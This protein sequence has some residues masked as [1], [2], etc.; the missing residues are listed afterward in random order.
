MK[1][2]SQIKEF[3]LKEETSIDSVKKQLDAL[4]IKYE[5]SGNEFRPFKVIYKPVNKSDKFYN[6]FEDIIDLFNLR[7]VVKQSMSEIKEETSLSTLDINSSNKIYE[8]L[9]SKLGIDFTSEFATKSYFYFQVSDV[10]KS[11][12]EAITTAYEIKSSMNEA[13]KNKQYYKNVALLDKKGLAKKQFS[14]EDIQMAKK[15]LSQGQFKLD[16]AKEEDK[17]DTIT[18]DIPLFIRMLEYSR[19]DAAEDMDLHDVTEKA[20]SLGKERGILQMDDYD[21][22]VG[23]TEEINE[24][25]NAPEWNSMSKENKIK[26]LQKHFPKLSLKFADYKWNDLTPMIKNKLTGKNEPLKEIIKRTLK[27]KGISPKK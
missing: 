22:I 19:E 26:T 24:N 4:G 17:V 14:D 23:A 1:D 16:E 20:I 27:K 9:K 6:K 8:M 7:S 15:M 13:K 25:M 11:M 2:L 18:M 10:L 3:F 21:E 5:M 12:N